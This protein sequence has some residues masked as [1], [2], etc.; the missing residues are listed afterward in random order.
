MINANQN[1]PKW[2]CCKCNVFADYAEA[3]FDC[4]YQPRLSRY[5][6]Q[7]ASPSE[8]ALSVAPHDRLAALKALVLRVEKEIAELAH[9]HPRENA[10]A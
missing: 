4:G 10:L 7:S 3:C 5:N 8:E 1:L 6:E 2:Y 9:A